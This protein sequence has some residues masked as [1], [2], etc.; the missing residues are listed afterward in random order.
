MHLG[1]GL[2]ES[3]V[4]LEP[5]NTATTTAGAEYI[6]TEVFAATWL[7]IRV[8]LIEIDGQVVSQDNT[9]INS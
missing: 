6:Y 2:Y 1:G 8:K 5:L 4:V 7:N 9:N 3:I